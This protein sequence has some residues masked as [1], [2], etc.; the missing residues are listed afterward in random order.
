MFVMWDVLFERSKSVQILTISLLGVEPHA[1]RKNC[2]IKDYFLH[3]QR[4]SNISF[5]LAL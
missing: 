5:C 3:I 2:I 4:S 1:R